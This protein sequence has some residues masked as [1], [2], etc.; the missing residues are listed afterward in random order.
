MAR[1]P[2]PGDSTLAA[3]TTAAATAATAGA[4]ATTAGAEETVAKAVT[5]AAA[6]EKE[7]GTFT[8]LNQLRIQLARIIPRLH[9]VCLE[10]GHLQLL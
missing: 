5:E 4:A 1:F 10:I 3:K 9:P 7:T 2:V 6:T 8:E